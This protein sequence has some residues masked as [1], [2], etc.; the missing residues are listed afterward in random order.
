MTRPLSALLLASIL[1]LH[2]GA[3]AAGGRTT[4]A[5]IQGT[6][7]TIHETGQLSD[8]IEI[9]VAQG[10]MGSDPTELVRRMQVAVETLRGCRFDE[11]SLQRK[12]RTFAA[13][14]GSDCWFHRASM[15]SGGNAVYTQ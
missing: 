8:T 7:M 5:D 9:R 13:R 10:D 11:A 14:F 6:R 12:G 15:P 4:K 1:S 3:V 2:A